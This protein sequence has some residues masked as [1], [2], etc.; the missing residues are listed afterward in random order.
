MTEQ[1]PKPPGKGQLVF[2]LLVNGFLPW[3]GYVWLQ[4]QYGWSDYKALLAVTVIP[5]FFALVG[6]IRKGRPDLIASISL[7]TILLSLG[8]AAASDDTRVLQIRESYITLIMGVVFVV[9]SMVRKPILWLLA[10]HQAKSEEHR[11][12]LEHPQR[13]KM[14]G[15]VNAVWGWSFVLEFAAKLWMIENLPISRVLALSPIMFYGVTALTFLWTLWWL[16]RQTRKT[17]EGKA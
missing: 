16:R 3:A 7:V 2:D 1:P 4:S 6:I 10:K 9:S 8:L 17:A 15:T 13:R 11:A 12:A 14:L 5:A